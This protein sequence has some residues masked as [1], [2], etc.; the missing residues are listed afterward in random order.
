MRSQLIVVLNALCAAEG[1]NSLGVSSVLFVYSVLI[2]FTVAAAIQ[3]VRV[4]V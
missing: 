3:R 4:V 2:D 1:Y